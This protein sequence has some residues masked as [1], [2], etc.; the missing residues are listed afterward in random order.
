MKKEIDDLKLEMNKMNEAKS[1]NS[2][3]L[4]SIHSTGNGK[5]TDE[6]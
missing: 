5:Q 3:S 1:R 6:K 2:V 4:K